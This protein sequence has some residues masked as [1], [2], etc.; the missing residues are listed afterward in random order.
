MG[1]DIECYTTNWY[2]SIAAAV[3]TCAVYLVGF[4]LGLAVFMMR[5]RRYVKCLMEIR[6]YGSWSEAMFKKGLW[7]EALDQTQ[8]Y[9]SLSPGSNLRKLWSRT[10]FDRTSGMISADYFPE[11]E[12][13]TDHPDTPV[14]CRDVYIHRGMLGTAEAGS[15][16]MRRA[17]SMTTAQREEDGIESLGPAR[18]VTLA[19][20]GIIPVRS[21]QKSELGEGGVTSMKTVTE[22]DSKHVSQMYHEA[23]PVS[24]A[25]AHLLFRASRAVAAPAWAPTAGSLARQALHVMVEGEGS[26][27]GY[28]GAAHQALGTTFTD[29]FEDDFFFWQCYEIVRR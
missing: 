14:Q 20:G 11:T 2:L 4:P 16:L 26:L 8:I 3:F 15:P 19:D 27:G 5:R 9:D 1:S 22:L 17:E 23:G 18:I 6:D 29:P 12:T 28:W 13:P 24:E 25:A 7:K 21:Y 10:S